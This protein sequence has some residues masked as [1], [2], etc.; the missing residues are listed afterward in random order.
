MSQL[1]GDRPGDRPGRGRGVS[2][3]S[4]DAKRDRTYI[5]LMPSRGERMPVEPADLAIGAGVTAVF[6]FAD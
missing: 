3:V 4:I 1:G 6:A 2:P 5:E